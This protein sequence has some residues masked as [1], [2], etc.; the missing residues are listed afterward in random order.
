MTDVISP[1]ETYTPGYTPPDAESEMGF[2]LS[3]LQNY[4]L[5]NDVIYFRIKIPHRI[6]KWFVAPDSARMS[7]EV[8][9]SLHAKV[10]LVDNDPGKTPIS[11]NVRDKIDKLRSEISVTFDLLERTG[12]SDDIKYSLARG[13][14]R[15]K[16]GDAVAKKVGIKFRQVAN[17]YLDNITNKQKWRVNSIK[18]VRYSLAL[19]EKI[20][21]NILINDIDITIARSFSNQLIKLPKNIPKSP[22]YRDKTIQEILAMDG[23]VPMA[24]RSINKHIKWVKALFDYAIRNEYTSKN[25]FINKDLQVKIDTLPE[26]ERRP[27]TKE[28]LQKVVDN[29]K[30]NPKYPNRFWVTLIGLH[31]GV[32]ANQ[33]CQLDCK[34]VIELDNITCFS[35]KPEK[36]SKAPKDKVTVEPK[37]LKNKASKQKTP[38]HPFLIKIGFIK[39]LDFVK[40]QGHRKLFFDLKPENQLYSFNFTKWYSRSFNDL[41]IFPKSKKTEVETPTPETDEETDLDKATFHSFRHNICSL[42]KNEL[43]PGPLIS[44]IAGHANDDAIMID[45]S[46]S[47]TRYGKEFRPKILLDVLSK[48]DW[49]HELDMTNVKREANKCMQDIESLLN[50]EPLQENLKWRPG[51]RRIHLDV[52]DVENDEEDDD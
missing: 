49:E 27:Y 23:V 31:H 15:T 24:D 19:F 21:G 9:R 44:A 25:P 2:L 45:T 39:Y 16:D 34:D 7:S 50:E 38:V 33:I 32:R 6:R 29:I 48:V 47:M 8:L 18:D 46:Q 35:F 5:I 22:L 37:H 17:E 14:F 30:W 51:F 42:L 1:F 41:Y 36:K 52:P 20:F 13:V 28:E 40:K 12:V 3:N 11:K 43:V 4:R 26:D 10:R